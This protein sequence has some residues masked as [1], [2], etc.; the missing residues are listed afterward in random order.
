MINDEGKNW[1]Y[2]IVKSISR[3]LREITSNHDG[4]FYCLSYSHSYTTKKRLTKHEKICK[5]HN[6]CNVKMP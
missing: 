6:F 1:H 5:D 4:E 3:L 2:L